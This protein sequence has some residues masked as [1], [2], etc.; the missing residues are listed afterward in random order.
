MA[1]IG[2]HVDGVFAEYAKIPT[3]CCWRLPKDAN[4]DLGA[5][6]E[7]IGVA[8]NG[9][10]FSDDEVAVECDR[11]ERELGLPTCD[12]IRHGPDKLAEAVVELMD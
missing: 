11:V 6:L 2:V 7:P 10:K 12:V 8:V 9:Q 5:I 4:P 1:I 3:A